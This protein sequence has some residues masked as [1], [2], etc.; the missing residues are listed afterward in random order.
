[1]KPDLATRSQIHNLVVGFYREVS[2]DD[3]LG[4]VFREVAETDWA[5]HI[6]KLIDFWCRVLLGHPGYEGYVLGAHR[7]VHEAEP[8]TPELFDRWYLLFAASV[9]ESWQGPIAERAKVHAARMA[10]G[11]A[12]HLLDLDWQVPEEVVLVD[13]TPP[14]PT[15]I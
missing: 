14:A 11:L 5:A 6:P 2:C 8:F 10:K 7:D 3:L 13:G 4:P 1:M 9:D 15:Q 12:H